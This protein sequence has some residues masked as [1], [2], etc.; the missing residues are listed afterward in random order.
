MER[1][2]YNTRR[3]RYLKRYNLTHPKP[4]RLLSLAVMDQL[5]ACKDEAARRILL[6]I[7]RKRS[8]GPRED[9][10]N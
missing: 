1:K 7:T 5:D 8:K 10:A 4:W 6:G 2:C 3:N 9:K